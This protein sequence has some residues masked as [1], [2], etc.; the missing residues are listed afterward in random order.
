MTMKS[1][2]QCEET[3]D[4]AQNSAACAITSAIAVALQEPIEETIQ[5]CNTSRCSIGSRVQ[6]ER[7]QT[8]HNLSRQ[9]SDAAC[10]G[11]ESVARLRALETNEPEDMDEEVK[12]H[13][14]HLSEG[15]IYVEDDEVTVVSGFASGE[16]MRQDIVGD[17][18][19]D[20]DV[21]DAS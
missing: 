12:L 14:E 20:P 16:R 13:S 9:L 7:N 8:L 10:D 4:D 17:T 18:Q 5:G 6:S 21:I 3:E 11:T 19:A 15:E 1:V 2:I